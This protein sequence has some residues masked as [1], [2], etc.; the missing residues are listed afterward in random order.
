M[1]KRE[2]RQQKTLQQQ[3]NRVG[4]TLSVARGAFRKCCNLETEE[5][6]VGQDTTEIIEFETAFTASSVREKQSPSFPRGRPLLNFRRTK[7]A[8][9]A[10]SYVLHLHTIPRARDAKTTPY[11][12]RK[13]REQLFIINTHHHHHRQAVPVYHKPP[14]SALLVTRNPTYS[15][16][17][18]GSRHFFFSNS[19][20]CIGMWQYHPP[21]PSHSSPLNGVSFISYLKAARG[22]RTRF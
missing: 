6:E 13:D 12:P 11:T 2:D 1:L 19:T 15:N 20:P 8:C 4:D 18:A 3:K 17:V 16:R 21:T 5:R 14:Q 7:Y 10:F 9:N 22:A